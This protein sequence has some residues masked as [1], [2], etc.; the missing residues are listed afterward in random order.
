[1]KGGTLVGSTD[2]NGTAPRDRPVTVDNL[3]ATIYT[4]L[5]IDPK[6]KLLDPLNRPTP[7]LEDPRPIEELL[8]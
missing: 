6:L 8:I 7:V 2:D 3:H 4:C 1:V 5:G